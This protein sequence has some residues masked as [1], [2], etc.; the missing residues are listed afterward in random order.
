MTQDN[1]T[2]VDPMDTGVIWKGIDPEDGETEREAEGDT[3]LV[4]LTNYKGE[5]PVQ[6][7]IEGVEEIRFIDDCTAAGQTDNRT[8]PK[9]EVLVLDKAEGRAAFK[10]TDVVGFEVGV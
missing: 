2:D 9:P 8:A 5:D 7:R 10:W 6:R 4:L 3:V 1:A